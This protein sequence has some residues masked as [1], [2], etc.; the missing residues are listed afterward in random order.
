MGKKA[1]SEV[2]RRRKG[3]SAFLGDRW[4]DRAAPKYLILQLRRRLWRMLWK[5]VVSLKTNDTMGRWY[6]R[7]QPCADLKLAALI[8]ELNK[9]TARLVEDDF[10]DLPLFQY[11]KYCAA[12]EVPENWKAK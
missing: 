5:R 7:Y 9:P 4:H 6:T 11:N 8:H 2:I 10:H 3:T 12:L 1:H